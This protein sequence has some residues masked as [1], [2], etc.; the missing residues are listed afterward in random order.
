MERLDIR[1]I[2]SDLRSNFK[3]IRRNMNNKEKLLKDTNI[4]NTL[5]SIEEFKS[6]KT[7][8]TF[9]STD[10]EVNTRA[11]IKYSLSKGKVVAVPRCISNTNMEFYI[12]KSFDDL[13]LG[14]FSLLEPNLKICSQ[15][16]KSEFK[17][18]VC[19]TPGLGFDMN[20]FR[21]GYGKGYYDRFFSKY[22]G[23]TIGVCYTSCLKNHI[24]HGRYDKSMEILVTDKF[25]KRFKK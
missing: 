6:A 24:P 19:I 25:I 2:K 15:L 14:L 21:I 7:I 8:L 3:N 1:K 5:I 17:S 11:L 9:V 4:F 10:I 23:K 20:G 13:E 22:N 12:I 16:N 18:S